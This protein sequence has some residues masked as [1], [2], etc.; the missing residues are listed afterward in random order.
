MS[1]RYLERAAAPRVRLPAPSGGDPSRAHALNYAAASAALVTSLGVGGWLVASAAGG[2]P[3]LELLAYAPALG[4][5][6]GLV[7]GA[8]ALLRF[9]AEHRA[10]VYRWGEVGEPELEPEPPTLAGPSDLR[11]GALPGAF[12]RG[13]DGGLHRLDLDLTRAELE[14]VQRLLLSEGRA[15]VR[16]LAAIVGERASLLRAELIRLGICEPP[17]GERAAALLSEA[18]RMAV[19]R[20]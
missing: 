2:A 10:W 5:L 1:G 9:T 8:V 4:G 3:A 13:L 19:Q 14:A 17:Q 12:V 16:A 6:A 7:A 15:T 11:A 18:G 20:W